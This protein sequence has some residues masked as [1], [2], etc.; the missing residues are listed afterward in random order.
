MKDQLKEKRIAILATNGFEQ[1]ELTEP[2]KALEENGALVDII[3]LEKGKIKA[4]DKKDWGIEIE[5]DRLVDEVD[6]SEYDGLVLPGGQINPDILRTNEDAVD[7]VRNFYN[8]GKMV[9]AICHGPWLLVE[10]DVIKGKKLT[11]YHS[12][13]TDL[14]NAG[15]DWSD[16]EV[17][18]DGNLITSRNPGDLKVFNQ[19]IVEALSA[20]EAER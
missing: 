20:V 16:Q 8:S 14:K 11:S 15:A 2:K 19:T 17:V 18:I 7:F 12:I 5:V 13:Q 6:P 4:W 1:V 10:A 9:A 3:S